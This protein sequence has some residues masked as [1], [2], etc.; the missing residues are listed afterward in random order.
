MQVRARHPTEPKVTRGSPLKKRQWQW[1]LKD[2]CYPAKGRKLWWGPG[3]SAVS[4][5]YH[6]LWKPW[7]PHCHGP[8]VLQFSS[9]LDYSELN[10]AIQK[11]WGYKNTEQKKCLRQGNIFISLLEM[12]FAP[13]QYVENTE[14][15]LQ[16][17]QTSAE[18][19]KRPPPI[20]STHNLSI[21]QASHYVTLNYDTYDFAPRPSIKGRCWGS[22]SPT[23]LWTCTV[24]LMKCT[25]MIIK[26]GIITFP[27]DHWHSIVPKGL[28]LRAFQTQAV[29][30]I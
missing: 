9:S 6:E 20:H 15:P 11:R 21:H 4:L 13:L 10:F 27:N 5:R 19:A 3:D 2:N 24:M 16:I 18:W 7:D 26:F 30:W 23:V 12:W 17:S 1:V 25:C 22:L 28:I 29:S 8:S 14:K